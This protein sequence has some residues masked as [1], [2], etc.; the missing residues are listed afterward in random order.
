MHG[1]TWEVTV[2]VRG[3]I[4]ENFGMVMDF[5]ALDK[6]VDKILKRFDH[7]IMNDVLM[8]PTC[9]LLAVYLFGMLLNVMP[10]GLGVHEVKV[11]EGKGGYAICTG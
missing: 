2:E 10:D 9:E 5:H 6:I 7:K 3:Q 8:S 11:R 4:T 1:H